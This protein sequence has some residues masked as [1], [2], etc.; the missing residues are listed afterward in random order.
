MNAAE[1]SLRNGR[2][3]AID[4]SDRFEADTVEDMFN[5]TRVCFFESEASVNIY[6][7]SV[8][9]DEFCGRRI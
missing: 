4:S 9:L 6:A 7:I 2:L 3:V 5:D 1:S 8:S